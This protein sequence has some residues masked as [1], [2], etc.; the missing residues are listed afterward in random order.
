[1]NNDDHSCSDKA[2]ELCDRLIFLRQKHFGSRGKKRFAA[3]LG[4]P[5]STYATYEAGRNPPPEVLAKICDITGCDL[6]WLIT[7]STSNLPKTTPEI[8]EI[9]S[10]MESILVSQPKARQA[11]LAMMD[12]L[13]TSGEAVLPAKQTVI[14]ILGRAAASIPALWEAG[15][16]AYDRLAEQVREMKPKEIQKR[17]SASLNDRL[18]KN[19]SGQID[20][21][22]FAKPIIHGKGLIDGVIFAS[23]MKTVGKLFAVILEGESMEPK[24]K[25]GDI[26]IVDSGIPAEEGKI[27]LAELYGRVGPICKVFFA[28][29]SEIR[30]TSLNSKYEPVVAERSEI[31][32]AF[33]VVSVVQQ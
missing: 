13:T 4:L 19:E 22:Q 17:V 2:T 28:D 9:L 23:E 24:L 12:L 6:K 30:L 7:G 26:V 33:K 32:W 29:N 14:P 11:V 16:E 31:K 20:I 27:C 21:V 25:A 8:S 5:L 15:E 1:V 18:F 10:R 3:E